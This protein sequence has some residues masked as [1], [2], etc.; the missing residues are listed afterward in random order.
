[1]T[2]SEHESGQK[3]TVLPSPD[4]SSSDKK[5]YKVIRLPNNLTALLASDGP[6]L[7][8]EE[9]FSSTNDPANGDRTKISSNKDST[10][11]G[12]IKSDRF[13]ACALS[14]NVGSFSEPDA[15]P[16]LA[17]FLEHM[18]FMGSE[19]YP[20]ENEFCDFLQKH[21][22]STNAWTADE[23]T[24]YYFSCNIRYLFETLDIFSQ[25]FISPLMMRD[26]IV[27][28]REAV[29]SEFNMY[30]SSDYAR[31]DQLGRSFASNENP[32]SKFMCGNLKTLKDNVSED[33]LY[34]SLRSFYQRC[35]SANLMTVS[36]I[37]KLPIDTL[38]KYVV[39]CFSSIPNGQIPVPKFD[40]ISKPLF[41]RD[42][43]HR[44]Y[45]V[46]T[47][48]NKTELQLMWQ[49][50]PIKAL[51]RTKPDRLI[52]WLVGHESK[53]SLLSYF[54][55]K[56]WATS[57]SAGAHE[58][59]SLYSLFGITITMTEDGF[60]HLADI[61][62]ATFSYLKLARASLPQ[63]RFYDEVRML[64]D[65]EFK[66]QEE[67]D[68][69]TFVTQAVENMHLYPA[70]DYFTGSN[71]F[72][73]YDPDQVTQLLEYI[74]PESVN[75][76]V[77]AKE[78]HP[79]YSVVMDQIEP[80]YQTKYTSVP[81]TEEQLSTWRDVEP[82]PEFHLPGDNPF[83]ADDF[84]IISETVDVSNE[85]PIEIKNDQFMEVWHRLDTVFKLPMAYIGL[86]FL[87]PT[88]KNTRSSSLML[89]LYVNLIDYVLQE[90]TYM[91]DL[92]QL[93]YYM[94]ASSRDTLYLIF[95]GFNHKL[96][97]LLATVIERMKNFTENLTDDMLNTLKTEMKKSCRSRLL[98]KSSLSSDLR[99]MTMQEP[100]QDPSQMYS[101]VSSIQAND[102]IAFIETFFANSYVQ[103]L[104]QGNISALQALN[105]CNSAVSVFNSKPVQKVDLPRIRMR[106]IPNG[107][108]C[109]L[110][111]SF[112]ELERNSTTNNYFQWGTANILQSVKLEL[113][114]KLMEEKVFNELRTQQ[115]L[116]YSVSSWFDN[117]H[118]I[119]GFHIT[120]SSIASKFETSYVEECIS[121]FLHDFWRSLDG[122]EEDE[123]LKEREALIKDKSKVFDNLN[124]ETNCNLEEIVSEEYVF[125][126]K[127][128]EINYLRNISLDDIK[129]MMTSM[130]TEGSD[131]NRRITIQLAGY[132]GDVETNVTPL[133][134][135]KFEFRFLKGEKNL[136]NY[137]I[138]DIDQFKS[139]SVLYPVSKII[140]GEVPSEPF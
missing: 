70:Q 38:E 45:Y 73:E 22:G 84:R 126:R 85:Y 109:L 60:A 13:A 88:V 133:D 95:T 116:G 7:Y 117:S 82:Y 27:R 87:S 110:M 135:Q 53:G 37:A 39:E 140:D 89:N 124:Q 11:V 94:Y 1:M 119:V 86:H 121:K 6:E 14:V 102:L 123:F 32:G 18:L 29:D 9:D 16:G 80:W 74:T 101:D 72:F 139:A 47:I 10:P 20:K 68:T 93:N 30:T 48:Q 114:V 21:G 69:S 65:L 76:I 78:F 90:D 19:K 2:K 24:T 104:V 62:T 71:L 43:F 61:I 28:E 107:Q 137:Y 35:Y 77:Q 56:L 34:E 5:T 127:T 12:E 130:M 83:I 125:D 67:M 97:K 26:S 112:N 55:S 122:F 8:R 3:L 99:H 59:N 131:R 138:E 106:R 115:Q 75:I 41:V 57:L 113:L 98:E 108:K 51:Y 52:S 49:M 92:A 79:H 17:H 31:V 50:P 42:K 44:M 120:V 134:D 132:K 46:T 128:R 103:C 111:K 54:K 15:I 25:F 66:F 64:N 81:I 100:H 91:A 105:V 129:N 36:I 33:E 136:E 58:S 23:Y 4:K 40:T 118:G 63:Q 96:P